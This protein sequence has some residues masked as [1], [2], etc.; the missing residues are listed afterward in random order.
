LSLGRSFETLALGGNDV[1]GGVPTGLDELSK[2]LAALAR[3]NELTAPP[4]EEG[5]SSGAPPYVNPES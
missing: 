4:T 5:V 1:T 3:G 2:P